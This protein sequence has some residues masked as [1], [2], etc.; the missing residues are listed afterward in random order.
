MRRQFKEKPK[1]GQGFTVLILSFFCLIG[2]GISDFSYTMFLKSELGGGQTGEISLTR[3]L[4]SLL[5]GFDPSDLTEALGKGLPFSITGGKKAAASSGG[6]VEDLPVES[7]LHLDN[8]SLEE[9]LS[10]K[11]VEVAIYH[12]HNA[13][14]YTPLD[15]KSKVQGKNGGIAL[16]GEEVIKT[17]AENGVRGIQDLTIHDHPDF[18]TSYIKS[19]KTA[20]RLLDEHSKLKVLI[21]LHRDAGIPKKQ[22]ATVNGQEAAQIMFVIGNGQG[23]A[24]PHWRENYA[25]A[26]ELA[27]QL[28]NKYP[29]IVKAVRIKNGCYNQ[30]LSPKAILIEIGSDK[31]TIEEALIAGRCLGEV[32]AEYVKE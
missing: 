25:F 19:K 6:K 15:N 5:C 26:R 22:T 29:G 17:L 11:P 27:N 4:C 18:P 23:I 7:P 14:T 12:T 31:N 10:K 9:E 30:N 8:F 28:Q 16:V 2:V 13:E 24:N 3:R 20:N 1:L 32:L 21:D